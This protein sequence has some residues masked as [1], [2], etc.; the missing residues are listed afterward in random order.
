MLGDDKQLKKLIILVLSSSSY[1]EDSSASHVSRC[2]FDPLLA[3]DQTA[4]WSL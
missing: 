3:H 2:A 4:K 1:E